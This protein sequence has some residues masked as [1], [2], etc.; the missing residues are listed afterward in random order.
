[1]L[2]DAVV[3]DAA[4][5]WLATD[6]DK[7]SHLAALTSIHPDRLLELGI[8]RPGLSG[9]R[10]VATFPIGIDPTGRTV[11]LYLATDSEQSR[12]RAFVQRHFDLLRSL[13][14]WTLRIVVPP[15]ESLGE[16]FLRT[17]REELTVTLRPELV[18]EL[19]GYFTERRKVADSV[20]ETPD[21]ETFDI[22]EDA[23]NMPRFQLLYRQWLAG[24]D[25]VLDLVSVGL[26]TAL[27]SG[28]GH[29]ESVVLPHAYRHLLPLV[30]S[31]VR[32]TKGA[33]EGDETAARPR[34]LLPCP[35]SVV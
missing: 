35:S 1:M 3:A 32:K 15:P 4:S 24:G 13:P 10:L 25:R 22:A 30:T 17:A 21:Q 8:G 23:F 7:A 12:F 29:I 5:T 20:Y 9:R 2:L 14:V 26:K 31:T 27:E 19:R 28:A 6:E 34:P 18:R 33:E 11:L 16:P